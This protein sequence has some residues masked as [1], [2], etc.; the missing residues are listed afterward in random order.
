MFNY[1]IY[2]IKSEDSIKYLNLNDLMFKI[3]E[4][5]KIILMTKTIDF[6]LKKQLYKIIFCLFLK[7]LFKK[8]RYLFFLQTN[9]AYKMFIS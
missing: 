1:D 6:S 2:I 5:T 8:I 4:I 7:I 3:T 9:N